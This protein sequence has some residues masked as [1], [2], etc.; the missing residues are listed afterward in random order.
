MKTILCIILSLV[1]LNAMSA[2][3]D[4]VQ[5]SNQ[6]RA[7]NAAIE[8]A[9]AT[10]DGFLKLA[11]SPPAGASDFKLKVKMRDK[12]KSEH[13]W[14]IPFQQTATGFSGTL[15][16]EPHYVRNVVN[17]QQVTFTRADISDWGYEQGGKQKGSFTVCVMFTQMPAEQVK[18]LKEENGFEC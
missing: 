16:N 12:D 5:F 17:G 11:K 6:D 10:L 8:K 18:K 9:R 2:K 7:M 15:A 4:V 3:D 14:V 1:S 13:M